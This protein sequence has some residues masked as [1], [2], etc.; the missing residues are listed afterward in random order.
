M[1]R[2]IARERLKHL[3][4]PQNQAG[5]ANLRA[6]ANGLDEFQLRML[7]RRLAQP[8][9]EVALEDLLDDW[10]RSQLLGDA[11]TAAGSL[12]AVA[13]LGR[14]LAALTGDRSIGALAAAASQAQLGG[15]ARIR[16]L[17]RAHREF[18]AAMMAFRKLDTAEA[19]RAFSAA[20]GDGAASG[21]PIALWAQAGGARVLALEGDHDGATSTFEAVLSIAR[22]ESYTALAAWC[23]WG[24]GWID[25][26]R[27]R[28]ESATRHFQI[29]SADYARLREAENGAAI[30]SYLAENL[31]SLGR[32][33]EAWRH[34]LLVLSA[35]AD[36]PTSLRRHV[37]LMDAARSA[38]EAGEPAAALALQSEALAAAN[39]LR[40]PVRAAECLWARARILARLGDLRKAEGDLDRAS[41]L[42]RRVAPGA[43]RLRLIADLAW[44]RAAVVGLLRPQEAL[45]CLTSA[46]A[47]YE[48]QGILLS[49]A[50]ASFDRAR[51]L[52]RL[53]LR[54]EAGADMERALQILEELNSH[55][56]EADLRS[57]HGNSI[58]DVYDELVLLRWQ[59]GAQ[60]V[61]GLRTLERARQVG[62]LRES[63]GRGF[64]HDLLATGGAP[65]TTTLEYGV[66]RDRLLIWEIAGGAVSSWE[67][68]TGQKQLEELVE[69]FRGAIVHG[70][71]VE[72]LRDRASVLYD[73]LIPM[74]LKAGGTLRLVA[75]KCLNRLPFSA[76]FDRRR[77]GFL[78]EEHPLM[79]A[80]ALAGT[81]PPSGDKAPP[82]AA[83][84]V[85]DPVIGDTFSSL[86]PLPGARSE[87]ATARTFFQSSIVLAGS[88]ATKARILEALNEAGLFVFAGHSVSN[89]GWPSQS[90]L[91]VAPAGDHRDLGVLFARDLAG[92]YFP[93]LQTVVL[94]SCSS[95]GPRST[96][97]LGV[98]GLAQPFL[99]AGARDVIGSLW[100]VEDDSMPAFL[101]ELYRG[102]AHGDPAE[103]ALWRAQLSR[104]AQRDRSWRE[105]SVWAGFVTVSA[106]AI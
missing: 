88:L 50:Y 41:G 32:A 40:D 73:L 87:I 42:T 55:L 18:K 76:L 27:D 60:P 54:D 4:D 92:R 31:A 5:I 78:I 105:M 16:R 75:D 13:A 23:E 102:L 79:L 103:E 57:G 26:R 52:L 100:S 85:A 24:L 106:T 97:S 46:I 68:P 58:Q 30:A 3:Q 98:T 11:T 9:R 59:A 104:V 67:R 34:R 69:G 53:H 21:S 83:L 25:S 71:P 10:G 62:P 2:V 7:V 37:A 38:S 22:H 56:E 28:F 33:Q 43:P 35:L 101:R 95:V 94:S 15:P 45:Q 29:A 17:A 14:A 51:V 84:L 12:R 77:G 74:R 99:A 82:A 64:Q 81:T 20:A 47:E 91:V 6:A 70:A 89:S 1:G 44:A 80:E 39:A 48:R 93:R 19:R 66:L 96:R 90:Y 36:Y 63:P 8:A 65:E 72:Q 86:P 61:D 49:L